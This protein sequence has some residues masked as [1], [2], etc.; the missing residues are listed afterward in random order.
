VAPR[1]IT[2]QTASDTWPPMCSMID[3]LGTGL[4]SESLLTFLSLDGMLGCE[5]WMRGLDAIQATI[6][7]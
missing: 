1:P 2:C 7:R 6:R 3:I 4:S 5:A